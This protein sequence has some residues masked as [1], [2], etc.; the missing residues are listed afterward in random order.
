MCLF[1][2]VVTMCGFVLLSIGFV[3]FSDSLLFMLLL[4]VGL[5]VFCCVLVCFAYCGQGRPK[6]D[7][8]LHCVLEYWNRV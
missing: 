7:V 3:L 5:F 6:H 8:R 4:F 2:P 1:L